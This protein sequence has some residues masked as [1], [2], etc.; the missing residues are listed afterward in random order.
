MAE[1]DNT[2]RRNA[3]MRL[4]RVE[5][6]INDQDKAITLLTGQHQMI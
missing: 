1:Y 3:D 5:D 6:K 2:E 4:L